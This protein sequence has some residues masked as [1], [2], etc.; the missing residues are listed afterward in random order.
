MGG[1]VGLGEVA[2][3]PGPAAGTGNDR[4]GRARPAPALQVETSVVLVDR[5]YRQGLSEIYYSASTRIRY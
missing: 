2:P 4:P 3:G 5:R 1:A